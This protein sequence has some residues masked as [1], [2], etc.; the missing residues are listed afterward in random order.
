MASRLL[1]D[2]AADHVDGEREYDGAVLLSADRVQGLQVP[3]L[4]GGRR[5]AHDVSGFLQL[6]R[7]V[8]L[9]LGRDDL[10]VTS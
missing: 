10:R 2:H 6:P 9:T 1:F 5:L 4:E 7:R 8:H 3:Q